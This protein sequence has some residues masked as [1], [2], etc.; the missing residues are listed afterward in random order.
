M[1]PK[2]RKERSTNFKTWETQSR[3]LSALVASMDNPR[4]DYKSKLVLCYSPFHVPASLSR[5]FRPRFGA[6]LII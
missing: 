3:L 2:E 6:H 5:C 4:L 1:P